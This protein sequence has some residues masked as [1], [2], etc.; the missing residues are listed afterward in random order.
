MK[1]TNGNNESG[2]NPKKGRLSGVM[3]QDLPSTPKQ[4]AVNI[5]VIL[6]ATMLYACALKI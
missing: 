3:A 5:L 2:G 1:E 6:L 4:W